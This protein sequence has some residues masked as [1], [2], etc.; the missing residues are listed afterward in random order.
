M[1]RTTGGT[2]MTRRSA[3][4]GGSAA[5]ALLL[6]APAPAQGAPGIMWPEVFASDDGKVGVLYYFNSRDDP[7]Q[8]NGGVRRIARSIFPVD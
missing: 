6:A 1:A 4:A 5:G 3:L 2:A 7:V 8:A